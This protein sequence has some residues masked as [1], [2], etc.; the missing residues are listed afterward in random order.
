MASQ[1]A[2]IEKAVFIVPDAEA[3]VAVR[4]E[5]ETV[6]LT[7]QQLSDLFDVSV[8]TINEHLGN[9]YDQRELNRETTIRKFR[10]VRQEGKRQ[11]E[12]NI[13]HYDLD[14]VIS[15]GYRVN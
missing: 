10:I 13:A 7:Q 3:E 8:P 6:W 2:P 14:A 15:V 9:I 11:V 12:R 4:I 1:L 5:G